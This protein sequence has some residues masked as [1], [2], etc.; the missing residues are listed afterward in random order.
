MSG[1]YQTT[2]ANRFDN[3]PANNWVLQR[4]ELESNARLNLTDR[5][6]FEFNG[7]GE[8]EALYVKELVLGPDAVLNTALNTLYYEQL[9]M[10]EGSEIVDIPLLG[11][12]LKVIHMNDQE[13][14][15]LRVDWRV[16]DPADRAAVGLGAPLPKGSIL[17]ITHGTNDGVMEMS[18]RGAGG[19]D[20]AS[21]AAKG[22]FARAGDEDVTIEFEYRFM[23]DPNDE[24]ELIVYLSDTSEVG[25]SLMEVARIRPPAD[26]PAGAVGSPEFA[27]FSG[28]F[29]RGSLNFT[30]GTYVELELR[31]RNARCWI[32]NWDPT[33]R[34]TKHCGDYGGVLYGV[35]DV[36]DYL[37]LLSEFGLNSPVSA[38]KGCLDLINDGVVNINDLMSWETEGV[39]NK[40][41]VE[42]SQ[43]SGGMSSGMGSA[44]G[45]SYTG[46]SIGIFEP[47]VV[48]GKPVGDAVSIPDNYLYSTETDGTVI[49]ATHAEAEG[50][51][52]ADG[53]GRLYQI[54]GN[55]ALVHQSKNSIVLGPKY[56]IDHEG[57]T[58]SIGYDGSR[59]VPILDAA[60]SPEDPNTV[61][62]APVLVTPEP[63]GIPYK[64]AAKVVLS[65][66][67]NDP[68]YT[69]EMIYG[70][71]P[72]TDPEVTTK[73]AGSGNVVQD[74]QD[75]SEIEV[76][77]NGKV[78]VLSAHG[79]DD[80]KWVLM[81][82]ELSGNSSR[83]LVSLKQ[84]NIAGP[85]AMLVS[86][87]EEKLYLTSCEN[88]PADLVTDIYRF[89]IVRPDGADPNLVLDETITV[90]CPAP[91]VCGA[92]P[93]V[94]ADGSYIAT[95][96][97]MTEN[98]DD[99]TVYAT[100]FTAPKFGDNLEDL[101]PEIEDQG[102]YTTAILAEI[103]LATAGP[104]DAKKFNDATGEPIVLPM[105]I[106]WTGGKL[107]KCNGADISGNG[108]VD[109]EDFAILASQWLG[110]AGNPSADIAPERYYD[111][112][113][114]ILDLAAFSAYWLH[115]GCN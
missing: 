85:M 113:V 26:D 89:S 7:A 84:F 81:Y 58:V 51:L 44:S 62:V 91:N 96:T 64:A 57:A 25:G 53:S 75:I 21:V 37:L 79:F 24:A 1:A 23:Y 73:S 28:A 83:T 10:A 112:E 78:Y 45:G 105:S 60:F 55:G 109:M 90:N 56:G 114:D 95:I 11:F 111:G 71:D 41:Q 103:P 110:T 101:P 22:A 17:R 42:S 107:P 97:A 72:N 34:C 67:S 14:F 13:E 43:G 88:E 6:G 33:I 32:D 35:V 61:F 16:T 65:G 48:F 86:S 108:K 87:I 104:V 12:S 19:E 94:C 82:D 4:L 47:L 102:I 80:S 68:N 3:E 92:L 2:I 66:T 20:A 76:G 59:G 40:C 77:P 38:N 54:L 29:P 99:G 50:R 70:M 74:F 15:D 63:G 115:S 49:E 36:G 39:L 52:V 18:T 69:I 5:R 9:T 93:A 46:A 100:G 8:R 98:P 31:G 106:A 27:V 30:R